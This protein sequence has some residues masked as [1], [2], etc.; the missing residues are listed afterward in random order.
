MPG[1]FCSGS[2]IFFILAVAM[3]LPAQGITNGK[4]KASPRIG[5]LMMVIFAFISSFLLVMAFVSLLK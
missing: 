5:F 1:L 4:I 3:I 2:L